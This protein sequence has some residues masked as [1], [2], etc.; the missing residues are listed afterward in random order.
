MKKKTWVILIIAV[1]LIAAIAAGL[2][3]RW[4]HV[5]QGSDPAARWGRGN[6]TISEGAY[7]S[8]RMNRVIEGWQQ[9]KGYADFDRDGRFKESYR[10]LL[11]I[12]SDKQAIWIEEDGQI[13]ENNTAEFP[14][15]MK[16]KLYHVTPQGNKE[17]PSRLVLKIRGFNSSQQTPEAFYLVGTGRDPGHMSFQIRS[18][19]GQGG[20]HSGKFSLRSFGSSK[21]IMN[22]YGSILVTDSEYEQYRTDGKE[23]KAQ[24]VTAIEKNKAN[25]LKVEKSLYGEIERQLLNAGF[26]LRRITIEPGPDYSAGHAEI[27]G[28]SKSFL[29]KIFGGSSSV[30]TYMNI[31]YLQNDL[32]YARSVAH[33]RHPIMPRPE[34][35]LEFLARSEGLIPDSG[36]KEFIEKGRQKQQPIPFPETKWRAALP[37]GAI[38]EIIGICE[39]P[40]AGKQWWG[41]DGAPLDYVPYINTEPY[42]RP[43][44]DRKIYEFAWRIEG[45][46]GSNATTHSFEGSKGSYYRQIHDRYGNEIEDGLYAEGYGFDKSHQKTTLTLGFAAQ[47]WK[48]ALAI[49]DAAGETK[50]LGKQR[51][52]LNPPAIENG[53]IVIRCYEEYRASVGDYKIDFG[54]IYRED[55]ITKTV[56]LGRYE[57][58]ITDNENTGL[59]EH[60]FIID[61]LDISQIEGV[62]F[63]YR[64]FDFVEFKNITLIPS[65]DQGFEITLGKQ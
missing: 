15:G 27:R 26:T 39:N 9:K 56:S 20:Y 45:P 35:D 24:T 41:P 30:E 3:F 47:A 34:L 18:S 46:A 52:L 49:E 51:I 21:K 48:T 57:E 10:T 11:V 29:H 61:N 43:R 19:G 28:N 62:C 22:P 63:R 32:W 65:Q 25:W 17:L 54:L 36:K 38:V 59:R 64:P 37:N 33:P 50:F 7:Y 31:D 40:S 5:G 55:S 8:S 14:P 60:K 12:D 6:L 2:Y 53:Q 23:P 1:L 16:W 13:E 44:E 42:G 4:R 58:D